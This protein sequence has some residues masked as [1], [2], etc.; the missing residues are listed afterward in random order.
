MYKI[1]ARQSEPLRAEARGTGTFGQVCASGCG[2]EARIKIKSKTGIQQSNSSHPLPA[3]VQRSRGSSGSGDREALRL[4][5]SCTVPSDKKDTGNQ[6]TLFWWSGIYYF[7]GP[8]FKPGMA[9]KDNSLGET[10]HHSG[11]RK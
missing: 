1:K 6:N 8:Y 4:L 9:A 11:K 5:G 7:A 10:W 2:L 3:N